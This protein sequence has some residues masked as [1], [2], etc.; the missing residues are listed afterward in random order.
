MPTHSF[1]RAGQM[2]IANREVKLH[3]QYTIM[4]HD[5]RQQNVQK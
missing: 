5:T 2:Y 4:R 3:V 1:S